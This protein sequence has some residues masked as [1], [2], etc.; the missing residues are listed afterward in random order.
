MCI[1]FVQWIAFWNFHQK[2]NRSAYLNV[3]LY[4]I[5]KKLLLESKPKSVFLESQPLF[6]FWVLGESAE[7]ISFGLPVT[8]LVCKA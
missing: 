3:L 1:L 6:S 8:L 7:F 5:I 4:L 2:S